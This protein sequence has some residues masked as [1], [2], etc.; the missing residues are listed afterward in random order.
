MKSFKWKKIV[1]LIY[2]TYLHNQHQHQHCEDSR[3]IQLAYWNTL[4]AGWNLN[5]TEPHPNK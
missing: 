3:G 2:S 4:A 5:C 1:L